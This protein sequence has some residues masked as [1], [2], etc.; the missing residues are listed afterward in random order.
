MQRL[1]ASF[2]LFFLGNLGLLA[3]TLRPL[4]APLWL[5]GHA[6]EAGEPSADFWVRSG[7]SVTSL[8]HRRKCKCAAG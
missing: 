7:L 4:G 3:G 6:I 1:E 5:D 2:G 8:P